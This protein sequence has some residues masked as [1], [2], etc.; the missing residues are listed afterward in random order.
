V[1][2]YF[3]VP[4]SLGINRQTYD[5]DQFYGDV[6][7]YIRF[8]TPVVSLEEL[9]ERDDSESFIGYMRL[10]AKQLRERPGSG[11]KKRKLRQEMRMFGCVVRAQLRDHAKKLEEGIRALSNSEIGVDAHVQKLGSDGMRLMEQVDTILLHWRDV[12]KELLNSAR[13]VRESWDYVDEYLS[14]TIEG[15]GTDL[16]RAIDE[17]GQK[18]LSMLRDRLKRAVVHEQDYRIERGYMSVTKEIDNQNKHYLYRRGVLKKFVQSVLWLEVS[19]EK[20]GGEAIHL[21]AAIAAA[22]TMALALTLTLWQ[23]QRFAINTWGFVI[24]GSM[25]YV[26]KDRL[27]ELIRQY[28]SSRMAGFFPDY[29]VQVKDPETGTELGRCKETFGYREP[30]DV[31]KDVLDLR[32]EGRPKSMEAQAKPEVVLYYRKDIRLRGSEVV[33][34]LHLANYEVNDIIRFGIQDFL[35]RAD[36]PI[37]VV[38]TYDVKADAVVRRS[39]PKVYHMNVIMVWRADAAPEKPIFHRVRVV[40]DKH[41]IQYL[42]SIC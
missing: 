37:A 19:K 32:H 34:R 39:F 30:K 21:G 16:I 13:K 20:E 10:L 12:K 7:S 31:P 11:E 14:I 5:R 36:D 41:G 40:F 42:D 24:A 27:K 38:P 29:S 28:M 4:K 15:K 26:L 18:G 23:S 3:F 17:S 2:S 9:C 6:F 22:L 25:I 35:V 8:K 33:K 1:E